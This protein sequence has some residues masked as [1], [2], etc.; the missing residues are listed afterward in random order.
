MPGVRTTGDPPPLV[1]FKWG[2]KDHAWLDSFGWV[3]LQTLVHNLFTLRRA[4]I[5][6]AMIFCSSISLAS[7]TRFHSGTPSARAISL[8]FLLGSF[9]FAAVPQVVHPCLCCL[10]ASWPR[11][12]ATYFKDLIQDRC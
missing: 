4:E 2:G 6:T 3:H 9:S 5:F 10:C 1:D 12:S 7:V 8:E 11:I